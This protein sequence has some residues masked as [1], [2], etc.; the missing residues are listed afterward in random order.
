MRNKI[1]EA[2]VLSTAVNVKA[3]S[4]NFQAYLE[5]KGFF[6]TGVGGDTTVKGYKVTARYKVDL[7]MPY[8]IEAFKWL[9]DS[10]SNFGKDI[11]TL[12]DKQNYIKKGE[13]YDFDNIKA[14]RSRNDIYLKS[15]G[16]YYFSP[17][18][19]KAWVDS[20]KGDHKV[21]VFFK[22]KPET[23][24]PAVIPQTIRSITLFPNYT[25]LNPPPDTAKTGLK[26]LDGIYIRDTTNYIHLRP[27]YVR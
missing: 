9:T 19:I 25:L 6:K 7:G 3:N 5:N 18:D 13:Q 17:D 26:E 16:Y 14:E 22:L 20:S 1:G 11:A 27:W 10:A 15:K 4:A 23:S 12:P 24:L 8:K 2:P 21:N